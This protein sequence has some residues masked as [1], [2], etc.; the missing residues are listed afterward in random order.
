[1]H[2][3]S[4]CRTLVDEVLK[5]A[6]ERDDARVLAVRVRVGALSGV[7]PALLRHAFPVAVAGT[8]AQGAALMIEEAPIRVRCA[9]CAV[10]S[11]V[12]LD[13]LLCGHCASARVTLLSG[14]ELLLDRVTL[15]GAS[16]CSVSTEGEHV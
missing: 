4:V 12:R 5:L 8:R 6:R 14:D 11:S 7:V 2:E 3:L 9:A 10:E 13:R 15:Q 16:A 1:V